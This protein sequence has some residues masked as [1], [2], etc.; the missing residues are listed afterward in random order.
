MFECIGPPS[1]S[2]AQVDNGANYCYGWRTQASI[3]RPFGNICQCPCDDALP[4]CGPFLDHYCWHTGIKPTC[5]EALREVWESFHA[6]ENDQGPSDV[7][8]LLA[9]R[10]A[11]EKRQPS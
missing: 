8:Q 6:H 7:P 4:R 9:T 1:E 10:I 3:R 5:Y 11:Q 2:V